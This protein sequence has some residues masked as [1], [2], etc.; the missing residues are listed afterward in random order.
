[1]LHSQIAIAAG[2]D[3]H[4]GVEHGEAEAERRRQPQLVA[5]RL[6]HARPSR[7]ERTRPRRAAGRRASPSG[8]CCSCR[9]CGR[10]SAERVSD[11][12][13][14]RIAQPRHEM[15]QQHRV[16]A[17]PQHH[18]DRQPHVIGG[19]QHDRRRCRR[20]GCTRP[21]WS[22][23]RRSR[24][25][26]GRSAR[27]GGDAAGEVVLEEGP[28]LPHDVPVALPADQVGEAGDDGLVGDQVLQ[29]QRR[30]PQ[31]RAGSSAMPTSCR[32]AS[33][34]NASGI[35]AR[36]QRD[37]AAHEDRD[38]GVEHSDDKAG[39]EERQDQPPHLPRIMP[40][41]R[42][43][44][45]RRRGWGGLGSRVELAFEEAEQG[46]RHGTR[47]PGSDDMPA[48]TRS[49]ERSDYDGAACGDAP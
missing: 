47:T 33:R 7:C 26:P 31:R 25:G 2:A 27:R 4:R 17:E 28:A 39:G 40:V 49:G 35:A 38:R 15:P 13:R 20:R 16:A 34:S 48:K 23:R 5:E 9:R 46:Y 10:M 43:Q 14:E 42:A 32:H 3:H 24:A 44:P 29:G 21:R 45:R 6:G 18:R 41:E 1:M 12:R 36:H 19:Q 22:P 11:M 8:C 30:R 37:D